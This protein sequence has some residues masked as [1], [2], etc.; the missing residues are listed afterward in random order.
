MNGQ[1]WWVLR[2]PGHPVPGKTLCGRLLPIRGSETSPFTVNHELTFI[3]ARM[4]GVA[5]GGRGVFM[6]GGKCPTE[7]T[8]GL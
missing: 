5:S 2:V 8:T 6:V 1:L 3:P 7:S 4:M